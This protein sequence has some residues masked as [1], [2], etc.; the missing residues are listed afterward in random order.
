MYGIKCKGEFIHS[1]IPHPSVGIGYKLVDAD[2]PECLFFESLFHAMCMKNT[3]EEIYCDSEF[4]VVYL[5]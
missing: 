1:I 5:G 2:Y 3:L 4:V